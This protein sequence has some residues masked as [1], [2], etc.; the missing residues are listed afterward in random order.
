[1]VDDARVGVADKASLAEGETCQGGAIHVQTP[2][3]ESERPQL[4]TTPQ[5]GTPHESPK[6]Q[7]PLQKRAIGPRIASTLFELRFVMMR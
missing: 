3:D 2:S 1:M 5:R 7:K 6:P 4:V